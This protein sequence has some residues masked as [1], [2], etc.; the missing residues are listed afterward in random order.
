MKK[1]INKQLIL[2]S[3]YIE[4]LIQPLITFGNKNKQETSGRCL[5]SSFESIL[6]QDTL[7][8]V[9]LHIRDLSTKHGKVD[10]ELI[11]EANND[12]F[13]FNQNYLDENTINFL[14]KKIR[15][16]TKENHNFKENYLF[17]TQIQHKRLSEMSTFSNKI[18]F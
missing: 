14:I 16:A 18:N 15:P 11:R 13:Q 12:R 1:K 5:S 2:F 6:Q 10:I 4:I 9:L 17:P 7:N 3:T 8:R